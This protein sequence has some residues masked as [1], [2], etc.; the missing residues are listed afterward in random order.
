M[1]N[2]TKNRKKVSEILVLF[3]CLFFVQSCKREQNKVHHLLRAK[4]QEARLFDVPVP[5]SARLIVSEQPGRKGESGQMLRYKIDSTTDEL[6]TF[7]GKQME[8]SGWKK[9][10]EAVAQESVFI[11]EKPNKV[12]SVSIR[13]SETA[14]KS[15]FVISVSNKQE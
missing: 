4:E 10:C 3:F 6:L 2:F 14:R 5:V 8:R 9:L 13:P 11:F 7:Y 15:V 1:K 12:C